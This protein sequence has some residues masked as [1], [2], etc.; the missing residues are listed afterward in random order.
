MGYCLDPGFGPSGRRCKVILLPFGRRC[1]RWATISYP[2][3]VF[4]HKGR[5][6][7]DRMRK[8]SEATDPLSTGTRTVL[9]TLRTF[10]DLKSE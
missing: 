5:C 2:R 7:R 6:Q 3:R 10:G 4:L 8:A 9:E 1:V